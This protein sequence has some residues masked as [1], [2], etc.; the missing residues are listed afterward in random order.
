VKKITLKNRKNQ[1]IVGVFTKPEGE[2]KGTCIIEHGWSGSKDQPHVLAIQESFLESGYQTF[3]FDATH[4][5]NESD[6]EYESSRLG[7]HYEDTED[8][9]KWVQQ[10]GWFV[11]ALAISGHSMGGYAAVRYAEE[12]PDEVSL[13]ASISPVVSGAL[14]TEAKDR[15]SPGVLQKWKEEGVLV[16]ESSSTPGLMKRSPYEAHVEWLSHNLLPNAHKLTMPVFLL[17]GTK[18][19]SCPPDHV[20][21]LFDTIPEGNKVFEVVEGAPHTYVTE[22]DLASLKSKLTGWLT[23]PET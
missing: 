21:Q 12:F 22:G 9:C 5:F 11:G 4:S 13:I 8:V 18:D 6:G 17:T 15:Y 3:N 14:T 2:I 23:Q 7:L 19:T 1:N 20:K 16:T 10:Q